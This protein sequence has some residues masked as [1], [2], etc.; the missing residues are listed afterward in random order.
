MAQLTRM[1]SGTGLVWMGRAMGQAFLEKALRLGAPWAVAV[2]GAAGLP[3]VAA[4]PDVPAT[5]CCF[6]CCVPFSCSVARLVELG[7]VKAGNRKHW[8]SQQCT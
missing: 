6:H 1:G 5:C 8:Q 7:L 3:V 4:P 2:A